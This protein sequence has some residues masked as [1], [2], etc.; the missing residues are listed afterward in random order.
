MT[1]LAT[2]SH[3]TRSNL[4]MVGLK[5]H[6]VHYSLFIRFREPH[7]HRGLRSFSVFSVF[8]G[9]REML[10]MKLGIFPPD[11]GVRDPT[12]ARA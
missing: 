6:R 1:I 9:Y 5:G 2:A 12:T 11:P 8:S 10:G 3:E 7:I 4:V